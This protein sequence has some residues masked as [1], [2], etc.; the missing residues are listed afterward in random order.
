MRKILNLERIHNRF[1]H[2]VKSGDTLWTIS[3]KYD[4]SVERLQ[5]LN[6]IKSVSVSHLDRVLVFKDYLTHEVREDECLQSISE[7][8]G[9]SKELI[10][11]YNGLSSDKLHKGQYIII[12]Y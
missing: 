6:N 5:E 4:V 11:K 3:K 12:K 7:H 2:R 1:Y 8:Y 10:K 9:V